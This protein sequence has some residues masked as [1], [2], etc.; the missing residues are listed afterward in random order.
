MRAV[1]GRF[2]GLTF[3]FWFSTAMVLPVYVLVLQDMG[4]SLAQIS[5]A[6]GAVA[7]AIFVFEFPSGVFADWAGRKRTFVLANLM[8]A[9]AMSA[10]VFVDSYPA[11]LAALFLF[12]T[13]RAFSSG[14]LDAWYVDKLKESRPSIDVQPYVARGGAAALIGVA[15]GSVVGGLIAEGDLLAGFVD[16][17]RVPLVADAV[18]KVALAVAAAALIDEPDRARAPASEMLKNV[19]V[20]LRRVGSSG[21]VAGV[22]LVFLALGLGGATLETF[23]QPHF[24]DFLG[25]DLFLGFVIAGAFAF[26]AVGSIVSIPLGKAFK[27]RYRVV[28]ILGM[29]GSAVAMILLAR[30]GSG[31]LAIGFFFLAYGI[32][33]IADPALSTI[34]NDALSAEYRSAGLSAAS[35][36]GYVG[37]LAGAGVGV[38]ADRIG[39]PGIWSLSGAIVIATAGAAAL[40]F[41][42]RRHDRR[43]RLQPHS[44]PQQCLEQQRFQ[45]RPQP[46]PLSDGAG[47]AVE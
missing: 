26:G 35:F 3:T 17:R 44:Q 4:L 12:G 37:T 13:G 38:L 5:L 41:R 33:G 20:F 1:H 6:I 45:R 7:L 16:A 29:V 14:S 43:P 15:L 10:L 8:I 47:A 23:W 11:V 31:L 9:A 27:G 25:N 36:A 42:G 30:A 19:G 46:Q 22:L 39:I 24:A 34:Y 32:K 18:L 2:L 28:A 40:L 21:T